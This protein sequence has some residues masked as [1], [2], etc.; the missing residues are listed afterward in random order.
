M[1]NQE[2]KEKFKNDKKQA[3]DAITKILNEF[4]QKWDFQELRIE[5][6]NIDIINNSAIGYNGDHI[7]SVHLEALL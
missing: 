2:L 3:E 4:N 6:G 1:I 5:I 7:Y